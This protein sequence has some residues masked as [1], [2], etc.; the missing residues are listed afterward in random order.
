MGLHTQTG[1][2]RGDREPPTRRGRAMDSR[3]IS[4][5]I[6][7]GHC[8]ATSTNTQTDRSSSTQKLLSGRPRHRANKPRQRASRRKHNA[9]IKSGYDTQAFKSL[10]GNP[11]ESSSGKHHTNI[12]DCLLNFSLFLPY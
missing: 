6:R 9:G 2:T 1:C 7:V 10:G 12:K 11:H 3:F 4:C 8:R 5:Y